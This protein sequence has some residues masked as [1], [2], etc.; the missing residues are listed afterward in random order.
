VN[1]LRPS[2]AKLT[3]NHD[4]SGFKCGAAEID[5]WLQKRAWRG[6]IVGNANVFVI[7]S[8]GRVLGF[9]A[10]STGGVEHGNAPSSA[11]RNAPNPIPILL[12]ARLGVDERAK[13]R[14][15][16][17]A[18]LQDAIL[19]CLEIA[20]NVGFRAL[21]IHCRDED[22]KQFYIHNVPSFIESPTDELHLFLPLKALVDFA[23]SPPES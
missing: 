1:S 21:L 19:R 8:E 18:L 5:D 11:K 9:Y 17:R 2:L 20:E 12:L 10:L 3:E 22:A 16:G 15:I 13:G 14:S 6:Q 4:L 7:E 23:Q